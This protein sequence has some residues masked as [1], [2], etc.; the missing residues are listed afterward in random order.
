MNII[1]FPCKN[2]YYKVKLS[3]GVYKFECWGASGGNTG[4]YLGGRGAY[5]S[6]EI[7]LT[8]SRTFYIYPGAEGKLDNKESFNGGGKGGYHHGG[9]L[10]PSG[11]GGSDIR[12]S[13]GDFYSRIIVAGGGGGAIS[14][15]NYYIENGGNAGGLIGGSGIPGGPK[16]GQLTPASGGTQNSGGK[17][18]GKFG[19]GGAHGESGGGGGY[20][21][22][23]A[24]TYINDAVS[25]GAGGSSFISGY[26]GCIAPRMNNSY[27]ETGLYFNNGVM[28]GGSDEITSPEGNIEVGHT[29][30]GYIRITLLGT[31]REQIVP[32][33]SRKVEKMNLLVFILNCILCS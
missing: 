29:G 31:L 7:A 9:V 3:S 19:I 28:K 13:I 32:C 4:A 26:T 16:K 30:D 10:T 11:G 14:V 6:G 23:G 18:N 12:L 17:T 27:H 33:S 25:S 5:V 22:G 21:G 24:S 1:D 20:Y 8:H 2:D 15:N